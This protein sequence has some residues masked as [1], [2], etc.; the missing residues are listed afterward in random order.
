MYDL[1]AA[2][3]VV[4]SQWAIPNVDAQE[5]DR[6]QRI[7]SISIA[8][9]RAADHATC[10]G[11]WASVEKCKPI[12]G[13]RNLAA[14][15]VSVLPVVESNLRR[16]VGAGECK[17]WECDPVQWRIKGVVHVRHQARSYWQL[18][19]VPVWTDE[20]WDGIEGLSQ[21]ATDNAAWEAMKL[22]AGGYAVCRT[23]EGAFTYYATSKSCRSAVFEKKAK[24]R[25]AL[26]ESVRNRLAKLQWEPVTGDSQKVASAKGDK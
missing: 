19:R 21:E 2:L 24:H 20:R 17:L 13:D 6:D 23:V 11:Q 14:A 16:N 3:A 26:V 4:N 15:F 25:A 10:S 8:E 9:Q 7:Y 5:V 1:L 22:L 18:H 12:I